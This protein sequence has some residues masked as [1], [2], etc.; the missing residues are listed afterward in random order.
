MHKVLIIKF[1]D[2]RYCFYFEPLIAGMHNSVSWRAK[3]CCRDIRGP[4][5]FSFFPIFTFQQ[6]S[7]QK[8][9]N[10]SNCG[11]DWMFL[12]ATFGPRAVCCA[13]LPYCYDK[14]IFIKHK[15]TWWNN[16]LEK[17]CFS[18]KIIL[19]FDHREKEKK[20]KCW[21]KFIFWQISR[22]RVLN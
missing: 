22:D 6:K 14:H 11:P 10:L 18:I 19:K 16:F 5:C 7:I 8:F 9:V 20:Q 15:K 2:Y 3:K 12:R 21:K 4:D 17:M 1:E 13:Y